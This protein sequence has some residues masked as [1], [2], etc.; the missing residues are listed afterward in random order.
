MTTVRGNRQDFLP[1]PSRVRQRKYRIRGFTLLLF[2]VTHLDA[3][4]VKYVMGP[5]KKMPL[6]RVEFTI[7]VLRQGTLP[8]FHHETIFRQVIYSMEQKQYCFSFESKQFP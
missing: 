5:K 7:A 8:W 2:V 1:D 6:L 3:Q 4:V